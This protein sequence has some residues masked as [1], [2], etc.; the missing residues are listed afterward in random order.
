MIHGGR[1]DPERTTWVLAVEDVSIAE[2][3]RPSGGRTVR[4]HV[5]ALGGEVEIGSRFGDDASRS[6]DRGMV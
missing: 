3:A 2:R 6:G 1:A 5:E 4:G